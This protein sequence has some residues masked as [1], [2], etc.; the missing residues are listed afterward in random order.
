M[1]TVRLSQGKDC[2]NGGHSQVFWGM[3]LI[4]VLGVNPGHLLSLP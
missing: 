4:C 2:G 3:F 1:T